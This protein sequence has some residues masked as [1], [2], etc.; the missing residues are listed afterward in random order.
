MMKDIKVASQGFK[1]S[2]SLARANLGLRAQV[3]H[4]TQHLKQQLNLMGNNYT[5][6]WCFLSHTRPHSFILFPPLVCL[7]S[8]LFDLQ[9]S[10]WGEAAAVFADGGFII[11]LTDVFGLCSSSLCLCET[12]AAE[13]DTT[14]QDNLPTN[15]L[16][17]VIVGA[18]RICGF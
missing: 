14:V 10:V 6:S 5:T 8:S 7:W 11:C 3:S 12:S 13:Q 4:L 15:P 17:L 16:I 1:L 2:A 18:F 9:S